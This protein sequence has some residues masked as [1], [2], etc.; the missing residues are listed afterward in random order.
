MHCLEFNQLCNDR[1]TCVESCGDNMV[2]ILKSQNM[3]DAEPGDYVF[4]VEW[5][6]GRIT[7]ARLPSPSR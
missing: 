6:I 2:V 3:G 5:K 7:Q 4:L 1:D